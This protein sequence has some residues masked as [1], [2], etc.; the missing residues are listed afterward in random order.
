[1]PWNPSLMQIHRAMTANVLSCCYK[2]WLLLLL[3]TASV[4]FFHLWQLQLFSYFSLTA[5][6]ERETV[7]P[8][9]LQRDVEQ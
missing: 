3:T 6:T 7:P 9:K 4:L 2:R 1:M 5:D 8:L